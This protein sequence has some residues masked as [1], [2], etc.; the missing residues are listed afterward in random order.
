MREMSDTTGA[1]LRVVTV[2]GPGKNGF[3]AVDA[4]GSNVWSASCDVDK[5]AEFSIASGARVRVVSSSADELGQG[6]GI[7]LSARD[8]GVQLE[9]Q[10][11]R[12]TQ[13]NHGGTRPSDRVIK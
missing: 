6:Q 10:R 5:V 7:A 3:C 4:N 13:H 1:Q 11:G 9:V 2:D 8:V 12:R